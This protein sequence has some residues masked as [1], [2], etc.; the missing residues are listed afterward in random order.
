[1]YEKENLQLIINSYINYKQCIGPYSKHVDFNQ[2]KKEINN[3][4]HQLFDTD[5]LFL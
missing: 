3:H 1:M 5:K 2:F 4:Y